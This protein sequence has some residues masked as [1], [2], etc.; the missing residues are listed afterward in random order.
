MVQLV[1]RMNKSTTVAKTYIGIGLVVGVACFYWS[2]QLYS[3]LHV[4]TSA[5][6][7]VVKL[8]NRDGS[9]Y[10]VI[11]YEAKS[12]VREFQA[13]S[14]CKPT[15]YKIGEQVTVLYSESSSQMALIDSFQ[16]KY[17]PS[18]LFAVISIGFFGGGF[19]NLRRIKS[20]T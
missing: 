12:E 17:A 13:N 20:A 4:A 9:Y 10:P 16:S 19:Y 18:L 7:S 3:F 1:E 5:K 14:G 8:N 6:G 15:C 11:R 2:Y